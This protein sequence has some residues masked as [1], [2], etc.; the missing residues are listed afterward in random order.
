MT[1]KKH[2]NKGLGKDKHLG[3]IVVSFKVQKLRVIQKVKSL[4]MAKMIKLFNY[5]L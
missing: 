4:K 5:F 3:K 1:I 2:Y